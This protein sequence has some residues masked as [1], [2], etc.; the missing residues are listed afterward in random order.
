[1]DAEASGPRRILIVDDVGLVGVNRQL[2]NLALEEAD[3]ARLVFDAR[4][5]RGALDLYEATHMRLLRSVEPHASFSFRYKY[6]IL[7]HR[8]II[9]SRFGDR[10][11]WTSDTY[12]L[13]L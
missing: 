9:P 2:L 3:N 1:M 12:Q 11:K 10:R 7:R 8:H 6:R 13:L 4:R 5:A